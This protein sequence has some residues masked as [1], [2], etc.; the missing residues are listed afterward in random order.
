MGILNWQSRAERQNT[1]DWLHILPVI[2]HILPAR[3]TIS[4]YKSYSANISHILP[5]RVT[6]SQYKPC[7]ANVIALFHETERNLTKPSD[8][9][10]QMC[11]KNVSNSNISIPWFHTPRGVVLSVSV[12]GIQLVEA[13]SLCFY[14]RE[15]HKLRPMWGWFY[16]YT[17]EVRTIE[18]T[19]ITTPRSSLLILFSIPFL[20]F[21]ISLRVS[22]CTV[23][24]NLSESSQHFLTHS[25]FWLKIFKSSFTD[26][27]ADSILENVALVS[28]FIFLISLLVF[29]ILSWRPKT[30]RSNS[31]D[32]TLQVVQ[33]QWMV[34]SLC[35]ANIS[36][37]LS[38]GSTHPVWN[39]PL[40]I[41]HS[42]P[43][44]VLSLHHRFTDLAIIIFCYAWSNCH[45]FFWGF[46]TSLIDGFLVVI[47]C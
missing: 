23:P 29:W 33:Y 8:Y 30:R 1:F 27:Y 18:L 14:C 32:S 34:T 43:L 25:I 41:S 26:S 10:R 28:F 20:M 4:Q 44:S 7:S 38:V 9:C 24:I 19:Y 31:T 3:V 6:V 47:V 5:A 35:D 36:Y 22:C 16:K 17:F 13:T 21:S 15:R 11:Y 2:S 42:I 40:Q 45:G 12:V 46:L 39:H 37:S